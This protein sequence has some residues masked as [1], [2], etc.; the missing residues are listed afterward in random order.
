MTNLIVIDCINSME[1][2]RNDFKVQIIVESQEQPSFI[3]DDIMF[4][5]LSNNVKY[6]F[7][8]TN[9][10][11]GNVDVEINIDGKNIGKFR[12][13]ANHI[14]D[15]NGSAD[16]EF[17]FVHNQTIINTNNLEQ[18]EKGIIKVTFY[19]EYTYRSPKIVDVD[20]NN[21]PIIYRSLELPSTNPNAYHPGETI[22]LEHHTDFTTVQ[23]IE[24]IDESRITT[25]NIKLLGKDK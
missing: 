13:Y 18:N 2:Q 17:M 24:C 4:V 11:N 5:P 16:Y 21:E 25:F 23:S 1:N 10:F 6:G 8:L 3:K 9:N 20:E 7:R 19:P 22:F 14:S 12:I 15:I